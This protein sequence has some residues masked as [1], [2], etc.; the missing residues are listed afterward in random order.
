MTGTPPHNFTDIVKAIAADV[1]IAYETSNEKRLLYLKDNIRR[2]F[3]TIDWELLK[4]TLPIYGINHIYGKW[5]YKGKEVY[6]YA[7]REAERRSKYL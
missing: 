7:S 5:E 1:I 6:L 4:S 2:I 3:L